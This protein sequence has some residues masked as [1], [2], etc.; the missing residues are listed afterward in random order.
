MTDN[1]KFTFVF[2]DSSVVE[3]V[4]MDGVKDDNNFFADEVKAMDKMEVGQSFNADFV[5][6]TRTQ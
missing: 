5:T 1:R 6:V 2:D 3:G 4:S